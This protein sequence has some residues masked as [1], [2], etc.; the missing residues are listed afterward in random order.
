MDSNEKPQT[1]TP[2]EGEENKEQNNPLGDVKPEVPQ[3][4]W[5]SKPADESPDT[6][7]P[8]GW[9]PSTPSDDN[10]AD[11]PSPAGTGATPPN[12]KKKLVA[13]VVIALAILLG[14]GIFASYALTQSATK[15][16]KSAANSKVK[17]AVMMAFSGGSSSMGYGAIK[18]VNLAKK[19]LD[20]DSLE[21]I[22]ED[23]KC[24][25]KAA[26]ASIKRLI[27]Q[28]VQVI[29][30]EGC[31]SATVAALP[32]ANNAKILM[33]SPS[34]SS[35]TL[36]IPNDYFFRVI[37]PDTFQGSFMAQ[38]IYDKG[39]R[40]VAVFYTN[41]PYG[42]GMNT[43]FREKFEALGGKVVATANAEPDVIDLK[44][45]INELKAAKPQA[46]FVAPN[47]VVTATA[48]LKVAKENGL[49]VPF[50][51]ADIMYDNTII[52]NA[53]AASEGLTIS[54]FP[55]GT[56][57]FKQSL[58]NEYQKTEQLY[59]APQAYDIIDALQRAV[60][61]GATTGEQIKNVLPDITFNGV[62]G[63]IKFDANGEISDKNYKYDLFEVK[64][65]AFTLVSQ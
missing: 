20:A 47:S 63:N 11:Q 34:A 60:K 54:S 45:Q 48:V 10:P 1:S 64:E 14:A 62:S 51:G 4:S 2:P 56:K 55:T 32:E 9:P 49:N 29:I 30:G 3:A 22:Q 33:I 38:A 25:A 18:G 58:V 65:G 19:Q 13:G 16:D 31:S 42:T 46:L 15:S 59:A 23:S 17:V 24:D 41:E 50:F 28:K 61:K 5:P 37:P 43:V 53:G 12:S 26:K 36:T 6:P 35:P 57:A 21:I 44:T 27:E 8:G 7:A 39:I 52:T 40:N